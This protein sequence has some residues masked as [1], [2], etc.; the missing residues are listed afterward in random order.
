MAQEKT[1]VIAFDGM[2]YELI[3]KFELDN[4]IQ[5]EFGTIDNSTDIN[6]IFTSELFASFITGETSEKH[7]V[8]GLNKWNNRTVRN[9]E[10]TAD[11][12]PFFDKFRGIRHALWN[13]INSI[14]ARIEK[15]DSSD[16]EAKTLFE[17]IDDSR[18]IFVPGYNP[19]T[20]WAIGA[21]LEPLKYGYSRDETAEHYDTREFSHRKQELFSELE[22]D[23]TGA[24]DFLMCHFHRIDTYQHLYGDK[25]AG[26]YDEEKL[27]ALYKEMDDLAGEIKQKAEEAGYTRII[28]MSDHGLPTETGHNE[29]AFYSSNQELFGVEKPHITDFASEFL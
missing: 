1:I 24:R 17:E 10:K 13:S 25:E 8:E 22:N 12:I 7:G 4:V 15:Y 16:L 9:I 18:A 5:Q 14:D 29:N 19:S 20:F 6:K 27:Y 2:D 11:R 28:F 23:F 21:D 3:Q 26:S